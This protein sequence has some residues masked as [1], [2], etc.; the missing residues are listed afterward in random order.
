MRH[1]L[2]I[3]PIVCLFCSCS[4]DL[5]WKDELDDIRAELAGQR[6]ALE[7]LS[8]RLY[9]SSVEEQQD[10][11]L[12]KFSDGSTLT[13]S[14][15]E[16]SPGV[17]SALD[18][19]SLPDQPVNPD[20]VTVTSIEADR[21]GYTFNFS[22]GSSVYCRNC[23]FKGPVITLIDDD[24][25]IRYVDNLKTICD[26]LGIRCN[27]ALM[28]YTIYGK[29][30]F[31]NEQKAMIEEYQKCGYQFLLHPVHTFWLEDGYVDVAHCESS[32]VEAIYAMNDAHVINAECCMVYPGGCSKPGVREMCRKWCDYGVGVHGAYNVDLSHPYDLERLL[33]SFASR[34]NK[35]HIKEVIKEGVDKGAW[36][37]LG[38]H[39]WQ[40]TDEDTVD[41]TTYSLANLREV[42]EYA[43]SLA[44][45]KTFQ[46]V[47][48]EL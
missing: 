26:D 23:G 36:V 3:L 47:V 42:L 14:K 7:K 8:D 5:G 45:F 44:P 30:A 24:F 4:D 35:T 48:S 28:P 2:L 10:R 34:G 20:P 27:F 12:V 37:I 21:Y 29:A 41:E 1:F 22:D 31:S 6:A 43:A 19:P 46:E 9:V 17:P 40:F 38:T 39:I 11:Y 33:V 15:W 32:L 16:E 13:L 25:N 18:D